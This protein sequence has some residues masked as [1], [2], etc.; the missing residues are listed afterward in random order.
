MTTSLNAKSNGTQGAL[1]VNGVTFYFGSSQSAGNGTSGVF[2]VPSG[3]SYSISTIY[4]TPTLIL[5]TELR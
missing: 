3:A 1:L 5:W 2:I 4:G